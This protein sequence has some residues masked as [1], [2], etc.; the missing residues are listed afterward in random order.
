V[1]IKYN[2]KNHLL[3]LLCSFAL[4]LISCKIPYLDRIIEKKPIRYQITIE[5]TDGGEVT[6][7]PKKEKYQKGE[8]VILTAVPDSE[9]RFSEWKLRGACLFGLAE[10]IPIDLIRIMPS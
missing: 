5:K 2:R 8:I 1:Y 9:H 6:V 4:F 10:I 3:W 7:S